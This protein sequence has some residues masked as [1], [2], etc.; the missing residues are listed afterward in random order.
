[1]RHIPDSVG[2]WKKQQSGVT[3]NNGVKSK[4]Y[5]GYSGRRRPL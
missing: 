2:Q 4:D 1:M 5:F 3:Q